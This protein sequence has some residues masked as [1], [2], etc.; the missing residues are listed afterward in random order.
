[1]LTRSTALTRMRCTRCNICT[2]ATCSTSFRLDFQRVNA[3]TAVG[4]IHSFAIS[5]TPTQYR[6]GLTTRSTYLKETLLNFFS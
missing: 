4:I 2:S 5:I 1:M 6:I 3:V